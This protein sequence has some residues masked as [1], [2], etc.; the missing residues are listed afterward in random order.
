MA[1][2]VHVLKNDTTLRNVFPDLR[3][4]RS[5]A[6][7]R[8]A[9]LANRKASSENQKASSEEAFRRCGKLLKKPSTSSEEVVRTYVRTYAHRFCKTSMAMVAGVL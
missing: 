1:Y 2:T 5:F 8:K 7:N 9:S 6:A 3:L 4:Q